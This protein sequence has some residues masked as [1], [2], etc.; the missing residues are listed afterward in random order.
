M[1]DM[2]S[3]PRPENIS[4]QPSSPISVINMQAFVSI[5]INDGEIIRT[6]KIALPDFCC[7]LLAQA[8]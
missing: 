2:E 4:D 5:H 1:L 8:A 3:L 6:I 7:D